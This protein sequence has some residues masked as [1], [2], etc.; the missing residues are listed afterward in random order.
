M[1]QKESNDTPPRSLH[2]K[3]NFT[4]FYVTVSERS[5]DI[6]RPE[7]G[8]HM[9]M[10]CPLFPRIINFYLKKIRTVVFN[11]SSLHD[12]GSNAL[13]EY[14][15][16]TRFLFIRYNTIMTLNLSLNER[17]W[18]PFLNWTPLTIRCKYEFQDVVMHSIY[19]KHS[20]EC[21]H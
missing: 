3:E 2:V 20:W 8:V 7:D 21:T 19:F 17:Y 10:W 13:K 15:N 9:L 16:V 11:S 1:C 12:I 14:N 6:Q 5:L 4:L 18:F